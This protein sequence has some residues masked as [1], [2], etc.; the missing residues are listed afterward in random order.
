LQ[1][2]ERYESDLNFSKFFQK[3]FKSGPAINMVM[4]YLVILSG[5]VLRAGYRTNS[6]AGMKGRL[7]TS[8]SICEPRGASPG[9]GATPS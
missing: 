3:I 5:D 1:R 4:L 8:F 6:N 7:V 9:S 2:K